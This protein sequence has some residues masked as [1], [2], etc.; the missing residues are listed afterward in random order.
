VEVRA[1]LGVE[2]K[3]NKKNK[4]EEELE[5]GEVE[6]VLAGAEHLEYRMLL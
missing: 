6:V 4:S 2:Y 5:D 1:G 3:K